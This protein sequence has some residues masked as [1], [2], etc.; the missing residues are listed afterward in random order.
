MA[1]QAFQNRAG[2]I[3]N[4]GTS[5]FQLIFEGEEKDIGCL[6]LGML[7]LEKEKGFLSW[8][9]SWDW[10]DEEEPDESCDILKEMME[11]GG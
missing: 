5:P 2:C 10:I 4:T 7:A 6:E 1:A 8:V 3:S 11:Y 9:K